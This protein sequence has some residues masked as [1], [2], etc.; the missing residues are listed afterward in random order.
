MVGSAEAGDAGVGRSAGW[1]RG[2]SD[3]ADVQRFWNGSSWTDSLRPVE[4]SDGQAQQMRQPESPNPPP[5]ATTFCS[6][7]GARLASDAKFC[8]ACGRQVTAVEPGQP[9][10]AAPEVP[11]PGP[12][13]AS[14]PITENLPLLAVLA[15]GVVVVIG[16]IFAVTSSNSEGG[17]ASGDSGSESTGGQGGGGDEY[18]AAAYGELEAARTSLSPQL[19]EVACRLYA[20][21]PGGAYNGYVADSRY[22]YK[23]SWVD[24]Q[25]YYE[26]VCGLS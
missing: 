16:L 21:N 24:Y 26:D 25:G 5:A 23:L 14:K 3:P 20:T 15:L 18:V 12:A 17:S 13:G 22:Q 7:C 19:Q 2:P 11:R 10:S 9:T 1:Y 6:E 8:Q 4:S